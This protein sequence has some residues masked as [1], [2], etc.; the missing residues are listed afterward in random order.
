[1]KSISVYF[2]RGQKA[3][4]LCLLLSLTSIAQAQELVLYAIPSKKEISWKSPGSLLRGYLKNIMTK[5]KYKGY[6]HP[7][8][9]II[10]ALESPE[11]CEVMGMVAEKVSELG[12]KVALDGYGMGVMYTASQGILREGAKNIEDL[13]LHYPDGDVAYIRFKLNDATF[14][15]LWQYYTEY[16]QYGFDKIYNGLNKPREGKGAGC[17]AYGVSFIEVADLL[18]KE[19]LDQW[20]MKVNVPEKLIGGPHREDKWVGLL[21]V[22]LKGKWADTTKEAYRELAYYEPSVMYQWI[23]SSWEQMQIAH[24]GT[25]AKENKGKAR[26]IVIDRTTAPVPYEPIWQLEPAGTNIV[27]R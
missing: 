8:G 25:V 13:H 16:K 24:I 5:S 26:G 17:S 21:R 9:H 2:L 27:A 6:G 12:N 15:R 1:M 22:L 3:I 23:V 14:N 18:P 10:V 20:Q 19:V 7:M 4:L 11:R